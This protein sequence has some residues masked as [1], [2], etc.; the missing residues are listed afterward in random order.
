MSY[1]I[2]NVLTETGV[3][4]V[5]RWVP[6]SMDEKDLRNRIRNKMIRPTT[7]PHSLEEL[8]VEQALAREALRLAFEQHKSMAVGLRGVQKERTVSDTFEQSG[9][10]ETIVDMM[11]LDLLIGSG[12]VLSHAPRRHQSAMLLIDS[13]LPEGVT[14]L[15]VDSIFM[16]PQLGVLA[17]V[18]PAAATEVFEKDCLIWLGTCAAPT[19]RGKAGR[20]ML[21]AELEAAG[22]ARAVHEV[23]FG[24]IVLLP[25]GVGETVRARLTPAKGCDLGAGPGKTVE[26][27]LHGGV[28]GIVLDGRGRPIDL[29]PADPD[30]VEKIRRWTKAL[31]AYPEMDL[32]AV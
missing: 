9:S 4:N 12:G 11:S 32:V 1:S 5:M 28:V 8:M 23:G 21:T 19:G 17:E 7:I 15:G 6:F 2:S 29:D 30:R 27:E 13:F 10:D 18:H 16:M 20:P 26:R 25:L 22:G 24:E 14:R 31:T 3:A